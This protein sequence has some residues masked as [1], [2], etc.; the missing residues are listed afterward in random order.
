MR[1]I[2]G[3]TSSNLEADRWYHAAATYD[4]SQVRLYLDGVE[5]GTTVASG[6]IGAGEL[7]PITVGSLQTTEKFFDGKIDDVRVLKRALNS[8][9][10]LQLATVSNTPVAEDDIYVV[11]RDALTEINSILGVL[12]NDSDFDG[13]DL[14][15]ILVSGPENGALELFDDGSFMYTPVSGFS[16]I[17]TFT[18]VASDES[19]LQS[20]VSTVTLVV[21]NQTPV[22]NDDTYQVGVNGILD[23]SSPE[24]ILINDSDYEERII[25]SELVTNVTNGT[26]AL[27]TNGA[28]TYLPENDFVGTDTFTYRVSDTI[29]LSSEATVTIIVNDAPVANDDIFAT[30]VGVP[31]ITDAQSGVIANDSSTDGESVSA[32]LSAEPAFGSIIFNADGS[33]TYTPDNGFNDLD[34]FSYYLF[35]GTLSSEIAQV[36]I[37]V[38][39]Q[40]PV[41][42]EDFYS[43]DIDTTLGVLAEDGVIANDSDY[44]NSIMS[45]VIQEFTSNG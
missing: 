33:F 14:T 21:G 19:G 5:I 7:L 40:Q 13:D 25:L 23:V 34:S 20:N 32:V 24:G 4:G 31:L 30:A 28:F 12:A 15:S 29:N 37:A 38:G 35:D 43:V 9:E 36:T 18:Y 11:D 22:A 10:V 2:R 44:E 39:N 17:D 42:V 16:E 41:A 3:D 1:T 26:L 45:A 27:G 6:D 8:T